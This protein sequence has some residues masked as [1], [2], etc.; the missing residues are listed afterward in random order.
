MS[1]SVSKFAG[2]AVAIVIFGGAIIAIHAANEQSHVTSPAIIQFTPPVVHTA[3]WYVAHPDVLKAN[4]KRCAGDA[5]SIPQAGCQ[6]ASAADEQLSAA[7]YANAAAS[8]GGAEQ[9][10]PVLK[11][12]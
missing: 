9:H 5:A 6:N 7:D 3:A 4:E 1:I 2:G 8:N 11:S 10:P 12:P